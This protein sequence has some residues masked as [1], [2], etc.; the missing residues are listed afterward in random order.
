[1]ADRS[2]L[3]SAKYRSQH[4]SPTVLYILSKEEDEQEEEKGGDT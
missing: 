1:M 2:V 3:L 4:F